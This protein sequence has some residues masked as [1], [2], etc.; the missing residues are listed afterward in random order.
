MQDEKEYCQ[1][2]SL[3]HRKKYAQF[4][5]PYP[6]ADFMAQWILGNTDCKTILDPAFGLGVFA[7]AIFDNTDRN[8]NITGLEIDS[9]ILSQARKLNHHL[10]VNL[11]HQDYISQDWQENY[12]GIICNPPYFKFHDYDNKTNLKEIKQKLGITLTGFTNLYTLFLLKSIYQLNPNGR[13]AYIV[14]S[15]FLNSDYGKKIKDYLIKDGKLRYVI[16]LDFAEN[17]FTDAITTS[18]ILLFA[19]DKKSQD[20][21]FISVKSLTE[22]NNLQTELNKYPQSLTGGNKLNYSQI[23]PKLKW[24]LYYQPQQSLNFKNLVPFS[25][26]GKVVRGIATGANDYF[27]FNL[28]KQKHYKIPDCYLLPCIPKANYINSPFFN[29]A[30]FEELKEKNKKVLLLNVTDLQNENVKKYIQLGEENQIHKKHL[31]SH[32]KPWYAIEKRP[33]SPIWVSVFNRNGLRFIKNEAKIR[34]LTTFH[35]IYLNLL[36]ANREDLLFAYLLTDVSKKIFQDNRREY[37]QGL[38][39]FEPNDLNSSLVVNLDC[40]TVQE[41]I[42][43]IDLFQRYRKNIFSNHTQS[44]FLK[45]INEIFSRI[46]TK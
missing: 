12:D 13:I 23:N 2:V 8:I 18:S 44:E 17:I 14:P 30:T 10:N 46:I 31:T 22:L 21:E 6:I 4:F 26:Y 16:I 9:L 3:E 40:I 39:K 28:E 24:R 7:R 20:L 42:K 41:E 34:N 25:A 19:H 32:R 43:I 11:Y 36:S 5:T 1:S 15:E 27:T 29:L 45:E 37:G 35:C 33:P 38:E